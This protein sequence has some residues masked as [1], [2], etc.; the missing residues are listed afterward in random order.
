MQ[1]FGILTASFVTLAVTAAFRSA[2]EANVL[3]L[4]LVWRVILGLG[5]VPFIVTLGLRQS[6]PES[7]EF[8]KDVCARGEATTAAIAAGTKPV[9]STLRGY[10][11]EPSIMRN[12]NFWVLIGTSMT[13]LL[14]CVFYSQILFLPDVLRTTGFSKF[15]QIPTG[16]S[17][18]CVGECAKEV[19]EGIF[20]SAAGNALLAIVNVPGYWVTVFTI[21]KLGR[22]RI[23]VM[24]FTMMTVM[25]IILA[26]FYNKLVPPPGTVGA[27]SPWVFLILYSMTFF[28]ANFGA[29]GGSGARAP[30]RAQPSP[31]AA[32]AP[33]PRGRPLPAAMRMPPRE[34]PAPAERVF[35]P[36]AAE[37]RP[38]LPSPLSSP[39]GPN[40]TTF[41]VPAEVFH[42][43]YRATLHGV[44][45]AFGKLGAV[46]GAFGF[47]ALQLTAG[48][49]PTLIALAIINFLG[50]LFTF[51]IP[52]TTSMELN[53]AST[54]SLSAFGRYVQ[55]EPE[56]PIGG[57]TNAD[58]HSGACLPGKGG[59]AD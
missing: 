38:T 16:G 1:G 57:V 55:K 33:P 15:P 54:M 25:L 10:L 56:C 13:S 11:T 26:G 12:R 27:I 42:T 44:S 7:P 39:L 9:A 3:K 51:F 40:T 14:L 8:E 43:R 35:R 59:R 2:V 31:A 24:G 58:L 32:R 36:T 6:M 37:R 19:W 23:Q 30:L 41:V 18:A 4:D 21:E 52:E 45:A 50:L 47:G 29:E 22:V 28:F 53:D 34:L 46:I 48:T 5:I 17:A 20:R 49:R